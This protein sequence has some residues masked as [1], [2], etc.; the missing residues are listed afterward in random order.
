MENYYIYLYLDPT[1]EFFSKINGMVINYEPFYVGLGQNNRDKV[2]LTPSNLKR[3]SYKNSKIKSIIEKGLKPIIIRL[4]E[5]LTLERAELKEK[6]I[7]S[8][9]GRKDSN[10]GILCN[11]TD[12]GIGWNNTKVKNNIRKKKLYYCYNLE[13]KFVGSFTYDELIQE[14]MNPANIPTAIKRKGTYKNYIW[15]Y[16]DLGDNIIPTIKYK[17]KRGFTIEEKHLIKE[18][19]LKGNDVNFLVNYFGTTSE[20]IRKELNYQKIY[21][22]MKKRNK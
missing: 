13:G 11:H 18:L 12:G 1:K 2:H 16:T 20:K 19:Y 4:Y 21:K 5:N 8:L 10:N 7:I 14:N 22:G 3:K 15:S 9:F 17:Q 6:E